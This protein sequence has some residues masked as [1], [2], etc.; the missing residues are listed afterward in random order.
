[1]GLLARV[2]GARSD[3]PLAVISNYIQML[4]KQMPETDPRHSIIEKIVKQT[5]SCQRN[6]K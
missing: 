2:I 3:T 6:R 1:L 5:L 4:A